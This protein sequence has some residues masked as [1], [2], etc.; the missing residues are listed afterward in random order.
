MVS[1]FLTRVAISLAVVLIALIAAIVGGK[2]GLSF[3]P[4]KADLQ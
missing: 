1:R 3:A 2:M 4:K